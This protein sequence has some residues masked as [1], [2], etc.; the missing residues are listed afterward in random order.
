MNVDLVTTDWGTVTQ[1]RTKKDPVDQGGWSIFVSGVNGPAVMN[2]AVN[3]LVRGQGE[4]GYFGWYGNAEVERLASEWLQSEAEAEADRNRLA[5][6]IQKIAFQ[7]VPYVPLG[8]YVVRTAY[9]RT[10]QGVLQGPAVLPWNVQK[11]A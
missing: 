4:R 8:Q 10:V 3:F 5:D 9:R 11:V 1:R 7:T 6:M 2:P